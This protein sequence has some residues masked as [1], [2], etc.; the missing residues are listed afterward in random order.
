MAQTA[1]Q[2]PGVW[3]LHST[4]VGVD[5][6]FLAHAQSRVAL[7]RPTSEGRF[8]FRKANKGVDEL[9]K[10]VFDAFIR[11]IPTERE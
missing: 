7:L 6:S 10:P 1:R 4:L 9:G 8:E 5:Y 2:A 11:F 3:R